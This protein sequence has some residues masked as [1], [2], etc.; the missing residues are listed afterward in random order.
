MSHERFDYEVTRQLQENQME[1]KVLK[2]TPAVAASLLEGNTS[3]RRLSNN[4]VKAYADL[5]ERGAWKLNGEAIKVAKNGLL[6]DGQ[7]RL[8]AVIRSGASI[9]CL[10][11]TNLENEIFDTLDQGKKRGMADVLSIQGELSTNVL[12]SVLRALCCHEMNPNNPPLQSSI[13]IDIQEDYFL[14]NPDV[15]IYTTKCQRVK[16]I[17]ECSV[18]GSLWYLFSQ[19]SQDEADTFFERIIDG[20]GL[21]VDSPIRILRERLMMNRASNT[22]KAPRKVLAALVVKAWNSYRLG[23]KIKQLHWREGEDFPQII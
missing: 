5:M 16:H 4:T 13:P 15:R 2:I 23:K 9:E 17:L 19:R 20:V 6:L 8:E 21:A 14:R 3:N 18:G 7:H 22:A 1:A 12:A 11:I 10:V